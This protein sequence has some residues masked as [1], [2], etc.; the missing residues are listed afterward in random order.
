VAALLS[1]L[2]AGLD[3][4]VLPPDYL[5]FLRFSNGGYGRP[6]G[7]GLWIRLDPVEDLLAVTRGHQCPGGLLLIGH[8][9][10][11]DGLALDARRGPA[12]FVTLS[13]GW[14]GNFDVLDVLG[15]TFEAAL[16]LLRE[17][18]PPPNH[19]TT[20]TGPPSAIGFVPTPQPVVE[21]MLELAQVRPG[22]LVVDLGCG[23]G[24][25]VVTAARKHGARGVGF[26]LDP[27]LL[28]AARAAAAVA[29]VRHSVAFRRRDF[30]TV[31]LSE[32][33][34]V[35]L[36]LLRELNE[37]LMPQL[38]QLRPG[39]RIVSYEFDLPFVPADETRLVEYQPG[40]QGRLHLWRAPL[41]G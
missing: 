17:M 31:D 13:L 2:A 1:E 34:V 25:I 4:L 29:G 5:D 7:D 16:R 21:A 37:R 23:D 38:R 30:F 10:L 36:Y 35:C 26:D 14:W 20:Y 33:D 15:G 40:V 12:E 24:R 9:R 27:E 8:T 18:A 22:E 3:G 32:A 39:A 6:G 11:G 19:W 41:P 28:Q